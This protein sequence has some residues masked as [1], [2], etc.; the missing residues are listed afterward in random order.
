MQIGLTNKRPS[1]TASAAT[2][3]ALVV[4]V[5]VVGAVVVGTAV[6]GTAV[7]GLVGGAT[8]VVLVLLFGLGQQLIGGTKGEGNSPK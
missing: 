3:A 2:A 1:S 4:G 7:V 5:T 8:V 6:V